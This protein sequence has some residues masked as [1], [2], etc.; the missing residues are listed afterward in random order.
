MFLMFFSF[1]S[2]VCT[3]KELILIVNVDTLRYDTSKAYGNDKNLMPNLDLITKNKGVCF[4][5]AF[6]A[7]NHTRPSVVSFFTGLYPTNHGFWHFKSKLIKGKPNL[8]TV[9]PEGF[10]KNYLN[11]NPNTSLLF[12]DDFDY[13]WSASP[14]KTSEY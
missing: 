2:V 3:A 13:A 10:K 7:S 5:N 9:L 1:Q 14:E 6:A 8:A 12:K 4:D 11:A